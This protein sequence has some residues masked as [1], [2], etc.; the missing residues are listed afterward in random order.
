[1]S[2]EAMTEGRETVLNISDQA[3]YVEYMRQRME[4][5]GELPGL[6]TEA[7]IDMVLK[8]NVRSSLRVNIY[9][10]GEAYGTISI[11]QCSHNREWTQEEIDLVKT[12]ADQAGIAIYQGEL[13]QTA[14]ETAAR[15]MRAREELERY[16]RRL[17]VSNR[18]LDQ[19]AT[20][21]SH[22]LQEPLRKIQLFSEMVQTANPEER[23]EY[24]KRMQAAAN[25]MQTLVDDLLV[26]SRVNRK[27]NPFRRLNLNKVLQAVL[28]DLQ[29]TIREAGAVVSAEPLESVSADES[30]IRQLLQN[31]IGN[32]LKYRREDE[33]PRVRVT[34]ER[35]ENDRAYRVTV[36]D[37]GIG[38]RPEHQ[39]RIFEPF[40]RLHGM[41]KFPGTGMGLAI[42][43]KI[44]ERHQGRLGV[45]SEPGKGSRFFFTIPLHLRTDPS[46]G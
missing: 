16:A 1:L 27:G 43:K 12:I 20:V 32:A 30:Q 41:G 42:C 24:L 26:L 7:L 25:R 3:Q 34:G 23:Q 8:Y 15:E 33:Q 4:S 39:E 9:Y 29:I 17:E 18:E 35:V 13:Y 2:P 40:Q 6:S 19:F 45:E 31:L 28:D 37:N 38:I 14:Q 5:I 22:D 46:D 10:R 21:A 36:E 11:S 44:V